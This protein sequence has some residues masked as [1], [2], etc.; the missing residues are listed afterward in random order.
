MKSGKKPNKN[1]S[2]FIKENGINP[3]NWLIFKNTSEEM[4]LVHRYLD[5]RTRI[6]RK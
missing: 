4:H 6:I 3:E 2:I 1:Q 5:K